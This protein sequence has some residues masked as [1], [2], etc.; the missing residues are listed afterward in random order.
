M[1]LGWVLHPSAAYMHQWTG[2]MPLTESTLTYHQLYALEQ[3]W[4]N[5]ESKFAPLYV[6]TMLN[7]WE[8]VIIATYPLFNIAYSLMTINVEILSQKYKRY[9]I[10]RRHGWGIGVN[11]N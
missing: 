3:T 1:F 7:F 11:D 2:A 10:F 9:Q 4:V 8:Y 6:T 5:F